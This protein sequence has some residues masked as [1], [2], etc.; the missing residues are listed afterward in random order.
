MSIVTS[1]FFGDFFSKTR[2]T[3]GS[4]LFS[5][6]NPNVFLFAPRNWGMKKPRNRCG[7]GVFRCNIFFGCTTWLRGKDLNQRPPGYRFAPFAVPESPRASPDALSF[8]L[9]TAAVR[10]AP[11]FRHRRRSRIRPNEPARRAHNP[12]LPCQTFLPQPKNKA[13]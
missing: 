11:C 12:D 2:S 4:L 13:P 7:I 5:V 8:G 10:F 3:H 9:S 1:N 6:S